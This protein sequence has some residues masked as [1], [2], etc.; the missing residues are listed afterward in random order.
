MKEWNFINR[1]DKTDE[2]ALDMPVLITNI[3]V[4]R[5]VASPRSQQKPKQSQKYATPL[6]KVRNPR[7]NILLKGNFRGTK[8]IQVTPQGMQSSAIWPSVKCSILSCKGTRSE[9]NYIFIVAAVFCSFSSISEKCISTPAISYH[10]TTT[11]TNR[12]H[13]TSWIK[14]LVRNHL[15]RPTEVCRRLDSTQQQELESKARK[16]KR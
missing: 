3:I 13:G 16:I 9:E 7:E 12:A 6:R 14:C 15:P 5:D 8:L 2:T 11:K 1:G 4:N 10:N